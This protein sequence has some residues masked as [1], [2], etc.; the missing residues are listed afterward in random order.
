MYNA[1]YMVKLHAAA[2]KTG[3]KR[4]AKRFYN[5][6]MS[7]TKRENPK[8]CR[9]IRNEQAKGLRYIKRQHISK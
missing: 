4:K 8:I 7:D 9:A 2:V 5:F 1:M 6:L 3:D